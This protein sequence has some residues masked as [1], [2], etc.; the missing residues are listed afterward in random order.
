M[1]QEIESYSDSYLVAL[2]SIPTPSPT[3]KPK[4]RVV[5]RAVAAPKPYEGEVRA[6]IQEVWGENAERAMAVADCE[7]G[8]N[9]NALNNNPKTGDYS[10]G[11]F[12]INLHGSL[13]KNRPSE[14]W[15]KDYKNNIDYAHKMFQAS[16]FGPWT[17]AKR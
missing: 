17:C 7:S 3:P 10:V 15:L 1:P 16:G 6:Y 8:F 11:V 12:Q 9:P 5:A 4:P 2:N 14:E 13:A